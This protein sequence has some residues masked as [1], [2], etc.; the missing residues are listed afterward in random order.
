MKWISWMGILLQSNETTCLTAEIWNILS[1]YRRRDSNL[2]LFIFSSPRAFMPSLQIWERSSSLP[3]HS[4]SA[5]HVTQGSQEFQMGTV[6]LTAEA[7]TFGFCP[8]TVLMKTCFHCYPL[9]PLA[10]S[11]KWARHIPV[12][13]PMEL[14][15][16]DRSELFSSAYVIHSVLKS[17]PQP[18]FRI[19]CRI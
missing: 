6:I 3:C 19:K 15:P 12:Y 13:R 11:Y 10:T 14:Q 4:F 5:V 2:L 18:Q 17:R 1:C 9:D 8:Q 16:K 7:S